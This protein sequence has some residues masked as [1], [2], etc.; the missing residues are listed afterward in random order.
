M[1][2]NIKAAACV[3]VIL[4][5][6]CGD[7]IHERITGSYVLIAVDVDEQLSVARKVAFGGYVERIG[8]VVT[9]IGWNRQYIVAAVRPPGTPGVPPV[10]YYL[11]MRKDSEYPGNQHAAVTGPL[12]NQEFDQAKRN[13]GLPDFTRHFPKLR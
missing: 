2:L 8:P 12:S 4:L 1:D 5:C 7:A 3:F 11:D 9:D 6:G 10:F 13:L